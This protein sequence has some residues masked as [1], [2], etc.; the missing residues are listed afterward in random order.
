MGKES[1]ERLVRVGQ[2]TRLAI[3]RYLRK[4]TDKHPSFWIAE[5]RTPT[6]RDGVKIFI[7]AL[8][9]KSRNNRRQA[10]SAYFSAYFRY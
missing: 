2:Q 10:R 5:N 1:K 4:R 6:T 3:N 8:M 9:R 7:R